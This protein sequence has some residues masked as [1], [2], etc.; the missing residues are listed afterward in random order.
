[1]GLNGTIGVSLELGIFIQF[2]R[3]GAKG[4]TIFPQSGF[5]VPYF[6]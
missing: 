1:M 3:I 4:I 6:P 2:G 5:E